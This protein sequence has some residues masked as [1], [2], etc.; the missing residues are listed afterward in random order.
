ML[1][2]APTKSLEEM[3]EKRQGM[4]SRVKIAEKERDGLEGSKLEA[5]QYMSHEKD[6]HQH[7]S[8]YYQKACRQAQ[9]RHWRPIAARCILAIPSSHLVSSPLGCR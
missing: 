4:V 6:K 3:N 5:E 2:P 7:E 1:R 9:V 8:L